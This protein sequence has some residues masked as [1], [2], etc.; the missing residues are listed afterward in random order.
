MKSIIIFVLS[1]IEIFILS[2]CQEV[3]PVSY[4][5]SYKKIKS[6]CFCYAPYGNFERIH[7]TAYKPGEFRGLGCGL[8]QYYLFKK[9]SW[10]ETYLNC[11]FE[12]ANYKESQLENTD[13]RVT[14]RGYITS[15]QSASFEFADFSYAQLTQNIFYGSNFQHSQFQYAKLNT[16]DFSLSNLSD[17]NFSHAI[18]NEVIS[19]RD[20]MHGWGAD[21]RQS[22]FSYAQFNQSRLYGDFRGANFSHA[23]FKNTQLTTSYDAISYTTPGVQINENSEAELWK[24]VNFT[25]ADLSGAIL[26]TLDNNQQNAFLNAHFCHTI[27]PNGK[28]NNR[29]C[30]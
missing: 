16:I 13:W 3:N 27:M 30:K 25:D 22:N 28:V 1:L 9:T 18:L 2:G 19:Q 24:N 21:F 10:D 23:Q 4:R 12:H 6:F 29:D 8:N 14:L 20:A 15:L 26:T 17:T 5:N 11:H 7:L